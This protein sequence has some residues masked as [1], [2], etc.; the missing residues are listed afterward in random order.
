[1]KKIFLSSLIFVVVFSASQ[2]GADIYEVWTQRVSR[3]KGWYDANKNRGNDISLC[4][5]TSA[6]N[7]ISWWQD[8]FVIPDGIPTG[9]SVWSTARNVFTSNDTV[10][11]S[12]TYPQC[13]FDWWLSG[14][15]PPS[16]LNGNTSLPPGSGGYYKDY[17]FIPSYTSSLLCKYSQTDYVGALPST[18]LSSY[19][20]SHLEDGYGLTITIGD[21]NKQGVQSNTFHAITLW[22]V[23][24]DN[25]TNKLTKM[26]LTDS[27]DDSTTPTNKKLI[28]VNCYYKLHDGNDALC[29]NNEKDI[30]GSFTASPGIKNYF[31]NG[32]YGLSTD[33]N[34][35]LQLVPEPGTATLSAAGLFFLVMWRRRPVC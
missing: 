24:Y 25:V 15:Y 13:V 33:V 3:E 28:E 32:V 26:W 14:N 30:L 31:V 19:I 8:Q 1:M 21:M 20:V 35:L 12:S 29:F 4:S 18:D 5:V 9:N 23:E 7:I 10:K 16:W 22:G 34:G 11:A 2:A 27:D 6:S 17:G